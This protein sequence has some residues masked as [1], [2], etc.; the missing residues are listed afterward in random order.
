[1]NERMKPLPHLDAL[2]DPEP[3]DLLPMPGRLIVERISDEKIGT[4]YLPPSALGRSGV[5]RIMALGPDFDDESTYYN[6]LLAIGDTVIFPETA[7]IE[8]TLRKAG[9]AQRFLTMRYKELLMKVKGPV[10][11]IP[12]EAE[13]EAL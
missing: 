12:S 7:G 5:G 8:V 11:E 3:T 6:E 1:M 2:P 13:A 4:L 9:S 10:E